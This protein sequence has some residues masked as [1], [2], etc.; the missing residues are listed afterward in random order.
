MVYKAYNANILPFIGSII[1]KDDSSYRY[2]V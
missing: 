1:A 2:L